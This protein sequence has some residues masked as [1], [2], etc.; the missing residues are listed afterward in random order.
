MMMTMVE[1]GVFGASEMAA[2]SS[3]MLP[4]EAIVVSC[5]SVNVWLVLFFLEFLFFLGQYRKERKWED[6]CFHCF[7]C[8]VFV[9]LFVVWLIEVWTFWFA[10][11]KDKTD[12]GRAV[13][14]K[15]YGVKKKKTLKPWTHYSCISSLFEMDPDSMARI[16]FKQINGL[17]QPTSPP[18]MLGGNISPWP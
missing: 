5:L 8:I 13:Q 16:Y 15:W 4:W 17:E 7:V 9:G 2:S 14:W 12:R 3:D 18:P 1:M 6:L 11:N 10:A